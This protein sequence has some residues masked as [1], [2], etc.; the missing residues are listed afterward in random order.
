MKTKLFLALL[1]LFLTTNQIEAKNFGKRGQDY[2]VSEEDIAE[3]MIK[4]IQAKMAGMDL[5]KIQREAGERAR[6]K[7]QRPKPVEGIVEASEYR[8]FR[9]YPTIT[10]EEDIK[11]PFGKVL[12]KK[13]QVIDAS[14]KVGKLDFGYLLFD[15][16]NPKHVEWAEKQGDDFDWVLVNGAPLDLFDKYNRW[17]GFDQAGEFCKKFKIKQVPCRVTPEESYLLLEEIPLK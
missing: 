3:A 14:K 12:A 1:A 16:D 17:V 5:D 9:Y 11:T 4:K 8:S 13:G 15:G 2:E 7:G 10:V 6:I